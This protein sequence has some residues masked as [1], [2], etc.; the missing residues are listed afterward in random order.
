MAKPEF[1]GVLFV[2]K[3]EADLQVWL[4]PK[5]DPNTDDPAWQQL[6]QSHSTAA[7]P[8]PPSEGA[9]GGAFNLRPWQRTSI[10]TALDL[11]AGTGA[12]MFCVPRKQQ[13][14]VVRL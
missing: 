14:L 3:T 5:V 12:S 4:G 13:W 7:R 11:P 6:L 8:P 1:V 10:T 2:T 9:F